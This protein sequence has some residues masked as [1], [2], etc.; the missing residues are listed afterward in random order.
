MPERRGRAAVERAVIDDHGEGVLAWLGLGLGVGLGV[1][2]GL[3]SGLGVGL[4]PNQV[5]RFL[6]PRTKRP[7]PCGATSTI[8]PPNLL[9]P[10]L[11]PTASGLPLRLALA[12]LLSAEYLGGQRR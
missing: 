5:E 3:G 2:L 7:L 6:L 12:T 10:R 9:K 11:R 8:S 4:D 1:G